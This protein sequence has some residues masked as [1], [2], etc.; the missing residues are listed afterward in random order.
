METD[1]SLL[2]FIGRLASQRLFL[3]LTQADDESVSSDAHPI[4]DEKL[5]GKRLE[6]SLIHPLIKRQPVRMMDWWIKRARM[7]FSWS[8][9]TAEK[10]R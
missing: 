6:E 3:F 5:T 1:F 9:G 7:L 8:V 2:I 10:D 4:I